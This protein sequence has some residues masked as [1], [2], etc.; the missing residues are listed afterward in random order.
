[1]QNGLSLPSES[2]TQFSIT[3]KT[4]EDPREGVDKALFYLV[5]NF[6]FPEHFLSIV[7]PT[8]SHAISMRYDRA[9]MFTSFFR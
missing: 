9:G 5:S 1:M 8:L 4:K 3:L 6:A 2:P 7:T